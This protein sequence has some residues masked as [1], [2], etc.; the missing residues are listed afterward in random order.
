MPIPGLSL[1]GRYI[2]YE[3]Q[4]HSRHGYFILFTS[5]CLSILDLAAPVRRL[6]VYFKSGDRVRFNLKPF[7]QTVVLGRED[8]LVGSD[9]EYAGLVVEEPEE[10]EEAELKSIDN[11]TE[12]LHVRRNQNVAPLQGLEQT[13]RWKNHVQ[14]NHH[15]QFSHSATSER[16]LFDAYSPTKLYSDD[17]LHQMDGHHEVKP[18]IPLLRRMAQGAFGTAERALVFAGFVQLLSGIVVYTGGCRESYINVCLAHLISRLLSCLPLTIH[19]LTADHN[20]L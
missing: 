20:S 19:P 9:A 8:I 17:T 7:W 14:H 15:H 6:V 4:I 5:A 18:K 16:T 3:G 2:R 10:S 11:A 13:T 1:T 12:P